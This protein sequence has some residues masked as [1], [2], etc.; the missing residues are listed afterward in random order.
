MKQQIQGLVRAALEQLIAQAVLD[1]DAFGGSL[2]EPQ[3]ER[4]R[5]DDSHGDF[6]TNA[7][8]VLAKRA[9]TKPRDAS[10]ADRRRLAKFRGSSIASRSRARA[11]SI[12]I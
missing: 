6:A 11:S 2:P 1:P 9:G 8:M 3:I 12:F 7:A 4:T 5:D 10:R